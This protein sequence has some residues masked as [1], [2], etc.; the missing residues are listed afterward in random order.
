MRVLFLTNGPFEHPTSRGRVYQYLDFLY[1]AGVQ[2]TVIPGLS[3]KQYPVYWGTAKRTFARA[4]AV[5]FLTAQHRA[6]DLLRANRYDVIV[7]QRNILSTFAPV[8][9]LGFCRRHR[10][11]VLD[12]DDF[13]MIP[14]FSELIHRTGNGIR[15]RLFRNHMH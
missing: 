8:F 7:I 15:S 3:S 5:N 14:A 13:I 10:A 1:S 2:V 9:E 11:V 4:V 6:L 12:F